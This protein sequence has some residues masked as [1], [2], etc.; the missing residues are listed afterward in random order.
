[1]IQDRL[2]VVSL[3]SSDRCIYTCA[4]ECTEEDVEGMFACVS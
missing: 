3:V 4:H 2:L 1:V